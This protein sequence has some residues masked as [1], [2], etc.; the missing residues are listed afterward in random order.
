MEHDAVVEAVRLRDAFLTTSL[1]PVQLAALVDL[2]RRLRHLDQVPGE[3]MAAA[4]W[5]NRPR[6]PACR[7]PNASGA[8]E[9][10]I[11][12]DHKVRTDCS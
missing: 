1:R 4:G 11:G 3:A 12:L 6:F 2:P 8:P 10:E 9:S 5:S 7:L